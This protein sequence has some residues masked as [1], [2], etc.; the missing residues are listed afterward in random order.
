[1]ANAIAKNATLKVLYLHNNK[2]SNKG[3]KLL[4]DALKKNNT[5]VLRELYLLNNNI[6]DE[7]A[8]YVADMLASN[9]TLQE[10]ELSSNNIGDDGAESIATSLSPAK[11]TSLHYIWLNNN[12]ISDQGAEKLVDALESNHSI[13][14]FGLS[15]NKIGKEVWGRIKAIL[16]DPK[17]KE[18]EWIV[19]HHSLDL[20]HCPHRNQHLFLQSWQKR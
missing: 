6:S 15:G 17:R 14:V 18:I 11:N 2:I 8:K 19:W 7:G 5:N 13:E 4:A 20:S 1:M 3:A 12:K 10:I 9:Q 16:S